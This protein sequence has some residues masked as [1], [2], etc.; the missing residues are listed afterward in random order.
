MIN[1]II[2]KDP[3]FVNEE[4]VKWWLD[5]PTTKYARRETDTGQKLQYSCYVVKLTNDEIDRVVT[6][7]S[8]GKAIYASPGI[9]AIGVFLDVSRAAIG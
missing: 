8:T 9:D 3:D 6:D 4:G 5:I 1:E 7:D 2:G